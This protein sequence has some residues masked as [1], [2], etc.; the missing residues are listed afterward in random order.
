MG[1]VL[2]F[3]CGGFGPGQP[4]VG[5]DRSLQHFRMLFRI[6][7]NAFCQLVGMGQKEVDVEGPRLGKHLDGDIEERAFF[8]IGSSLV[9]LVQGKRELGSACRLS[10]AAVLLTRTK[11]LDA[12]SVLLLCLLVKLFHLSL[13]A[14]ASNFW[15]GRSKQLSQTQDG[16]IPCVARQSTRQREVSN[17][18]FTFKPMNEQ[19][20]HTIAKWHYQD[21]Y[22]F[23][24]TDQDP[25]D[26]TEL[27]NPQS[28]Q[29]TYH[30]VLYAQT[31]LICFF[32]FNNHEH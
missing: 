17:L 6:R 23:Y 15:N 3:D 9:A 30:S 25:D 5:T 19:D 27:L 8:A 11:V 1:M 21:P 18:R 31:Q 13:R 10:H 16:I 20:A 7:G 4:L 28:W 26:L 29:E 2:R 22:T 24:D 14:I 32:T 12:S